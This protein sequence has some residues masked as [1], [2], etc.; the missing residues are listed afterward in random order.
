MLISQL[1]NFIDENNAVFVIGNSHELE[2]K[3]E[4]LRYNSALVFES[5]KNVHPPEPGIYSKMKLYVV[6]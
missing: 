2:F 6:Q 1:L 4:R 3:T 5:G